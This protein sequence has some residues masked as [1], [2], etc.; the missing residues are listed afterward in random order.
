MSSS[1]TKIPALLTSK[2]FTYHHFSE[3]LGKTILASFPPGLAYESTTLP[4][5]LPD[6]ELMSPK[7]WL[8]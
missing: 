3:F 6:L 8:S 4:L 1:P 5:F 2:D 7:A